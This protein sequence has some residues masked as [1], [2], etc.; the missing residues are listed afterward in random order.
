MG[1][2]PPAAQADYTAGTFPNTK[3]HPYNENNARI[4]LVILHPVDG[5]EIWRSPPRMYKPE[6]LRG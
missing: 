2:L 6:I 3:L 1:H 5:S 4:P